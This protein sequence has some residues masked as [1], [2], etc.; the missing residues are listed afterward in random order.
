MENISSQI[1]GAKLLTNKA[2]Q[3]LTMWFFYMEHVYENKSSSNYASNPQ[4]S[5]LLILS[6][7]MF[8]NVVAVMQPP[9]TRS[10][11]PKIKE[12]F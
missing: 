1:L 8:Q 11:Q 7:Q 4:G 10:M 12:Y 2:M 6:E 9:S 3:S 5:L